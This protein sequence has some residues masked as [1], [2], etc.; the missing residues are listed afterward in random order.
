MVIYSTTTLVMSLRLFQQHLGPIH[1]QRR[2][3]VMKTGQ[4]TLCTCTGTY[5]YTSFETNPHSLSSVEVAMYMKNTDQGLLKFLTKMMHSVRQS[6]A[7]CLKPTYKSKHI[8]ISG[9][10]V[11]YQ[12]Y[13]FAPSTHV[14][15]LFTFLLLRLFCAMEGH[16]N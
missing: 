12:F 14:V 9:F 6:T 5:M 1:I 13:S 16:W 10:F 3:Q 11:P 2:G 7:S 15:H 4:C 8:Q